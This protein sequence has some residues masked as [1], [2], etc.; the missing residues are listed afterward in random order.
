MV[1]IPNK[2]YFGLPGSMDSKPR[3][4]N[5][6]AQLIDLGMPFMELPKWLGLEPLPTQLGGVQSM[7]RVHGC[8]I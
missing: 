6:S 5:C 1:L 2:S 3:L 4:P 7:Q 8:K